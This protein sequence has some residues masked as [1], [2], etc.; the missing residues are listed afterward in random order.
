[1]TPYIM[2]VIEFLYS[3]Y[4]EKIMNRL[5]P[6]FMLHLVSV[7]FL[8]YLSEQERNAKAEAIENEFDMATI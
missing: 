1:M 2:I 3:K 6:P 4:S 8:V 5:M 7:F